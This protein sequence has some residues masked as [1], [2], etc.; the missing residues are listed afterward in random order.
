MTRVRKPI[1]EFLIN[2]RMWSST[3]NDI[4][5]RKLGRLIYKLLK[6][7][8]GGVKV[9]RETSDWG[10]Q[11]KGAVGPF[12]L[13]KTSTVVEFNSEQEKLVLDRL[14]QLAIP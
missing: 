12:G 14:Y 13:C 6:S 7:L 11:G 5:N 3:P 4:D 1:A 2:Y 9:G 10:E 8:A